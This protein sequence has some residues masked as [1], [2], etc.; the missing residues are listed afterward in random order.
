MADEVIYID[1]DDG[2][3]RVMN[4]TKLFV[5]LLVKFKEDQTLGKIESALSAGNMEE[6]QTAA[7]TLKGLTANLSLIELYKQCVELEA[8]IKAGS[9]KDGQLA[10]VNDV[11]KKTLLEIDKVVSEYA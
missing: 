7:H 10:L 11:Y 6:A 9:V 1:V 8:Q 4:N 3:K 2:A 5:K